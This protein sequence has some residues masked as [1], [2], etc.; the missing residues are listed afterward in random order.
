ML[1]VL[2]KL[3]SV[4]KQGKIGLKKHLKTC[5]SPIVRQDT[6]HKDTAFLAFIAIFT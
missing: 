4:S 1:S 2:H 5:A 3:I 6:A